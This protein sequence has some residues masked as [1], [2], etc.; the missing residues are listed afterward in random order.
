MKARVADASGN[1]YFTLSLAAFAT[2]SSPDIGM[3]EVQYYFT[4]SSVIVPN[5]RDGDSAPK[6]SKPTPTPAPAPS[7]QMTHTDDQAASKAPVDAVRASSSSAA[8][9]RASKEA[10]PA[11]DAAWASSSRAAGE[12]K[13]R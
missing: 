5:N 8:A 12:V 13:S 10:K 9:A 7:P 2:L 1:E 3:V 4:D 11:A 6:D